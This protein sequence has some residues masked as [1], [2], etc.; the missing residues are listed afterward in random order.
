M[1]SSE[2]TV[3]DALPEIPAVAD[4]EASVAEA[5]VEVEEAAAREPAEIEPSA[6]EPLAIESAALEEVTAHPEPVAEHAPQVETEPPAT[7]VKP[8]GPRSLGIDPAV[9]E[10]KRKA[11]ES[12]DRAVAAHASSEIVEGLATAAVKGGLLVDVD[13]VRGFLPASQAS[14]GAGVAIETLVKQKLPLKIIDVDASRKRVVVSHRRAAESQKRAARSTLLRSLAIGQKYTVTVAR[15]ADF[16]AFVELGSGIDGLVPM[17]ELAFERV[18]KVGDLLK[19]GDT[20]EAS[21]IRIEDGGRKIALSRKAALPDPWRDH[22]DVVKIG[23]TIEGKVVGKEPR[24]Q[25]EIA[26]GVV[27]AVRESDADPAE[28]EIGEA[29]EVSVRNLDRRTRRITLTTLHGAAAA[30][31]TTAKTSSG[32]ATLGEELMNRS[33]KR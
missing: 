1:E 22:A 18:E 20:F 8:N 16:G 2:A 24:L 11:Q 25:V 23:A 29:I 5:A 4:G 17:S 12:W 14:P 13:G 28:Y 19:V 10:R 32:F 9:I 30:I 7:D 21:V 33:K 27:G 3:I 26:P 15:L 31:V 6:V